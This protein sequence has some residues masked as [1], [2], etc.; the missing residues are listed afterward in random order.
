MK[1]LKYLVFT[2]MLFMLLVCNVS[3]ETY[4]TV[5][6]DQATT[7]DDYSCEVPSYTI[8]I[9]SNDLEY[10]E[11]VDAHS[12]SYG[13]TYVDDEY[14]LYTN[15]YGYYLY[16]NN[17]NRINT[18]DG[19]IEVLIKED[20][21]VEGDEYNVYYF[22]VDYPRQ[23]D[24]TR[25]GDRAKV[26]KIDNELYIRLVTD[27][28]QVIA[29]EKD[30]SDAYENEWREIAPNGYYVFP[31]IKPVQTIEDGFDFYTFFGAINK[32]GLP[33]EMW[34][35]D[36]YDP[37]NKHYYMTLEFD[38]LHGETHIVEYKWQED[39]V[40]SHLKN[41]IKEIEKNI[42]KNTQSLSHYGAPGNGVYFSVEDLNF[43]NYV[44]NNYQGLNEAVIPYSSDIKRI[45]NYNNFTYHFDFRAG[46]PTPFYNI[47]FGYLL[48]EK[49]G[50][51]YSTML[52]TG[53][54]IKP[55]IY[56]PDNTKDT[57]A[58][59]MEAA[60]K[61][62]KDYLQID[63]VS[64]SV[65]GTRDELTAQ[66]R[67]LEDGWGKIY[68]E[69]KLSDNYYKLNINGNEVE[70]VIEKSTQKAKEME[71]KTKDIDSKVEINTTSG[72]VPHDTSIE[73][74][75][76]GKDHKDFEKFLEALGKD[77]ADIYDLKLYSESKGRYIT[78]LPNGKFQVRI[79]LKDEYKNKKLKVYYVDDNGSKEEYDVTLSSDGNY[80]IFETTHFSTYSLVSEGTLS[81]PNTLDN[82]GLFFIL[83]SISLIGV[84]SSL[85]LMKKNN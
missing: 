6:S 44:Y 70:C 48:I 38:S 66:Y 53:V 13:G 54:G 37:N 40:P 36:E 2:S 22:T 15:Q 45:F 21:L 52:T 32:K 58:A 30:V 47:M 56:I 46:N 5:V 59:Y 80:A 76:I 34:P 8:T 4:S 50:L 63:N 57:D 83:G 62:I 7:C 14:Q 81:N 69:N 19:E 3:A 55:V 1:R 64:M 42:K 27:T 33:Y 43:V 12:P 11:R 67:E 79:P 49:D 25:I 68:N 41:E 17:Y 18:V 65:V 9:S 23:L 61:R 29:L 84:I 10:V 73:V 72:L 35:A 39:S 71:F 20:N 16:D 28:L 78:E 75:V 74:E 77:N 31:A 24:K 26:V 51:L 85:K 60:I 82:V